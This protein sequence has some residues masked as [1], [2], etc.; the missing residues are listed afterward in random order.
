MK[1]RKPVLLALTLLALCAGGCGGRGAGDAVEHGGGAG[2]RSRVASERG[3]ADAV[4]GRG[5]NGT[6]ERGGRGGG[7]G[8]S[9]K[10]F[11]QK[12]GK[13]IDKERHADIDAISKKPKLVDTLRYNALMDSL[14]NGDTTGLWP[15]KSA[16]YPYKGAI[17]PYYR[18]VAYYGN[19]YS[20]RMGV[21]GEYP[22]DTLWQKL[23]AEV[24]KWEKADPSTPVK[25]AI[26]YIVTT[27]QGE[28]GKDSLSRMRMPKSQIDSALSIARLGD[29]LL[30]F[31][32]QAGLSNLRHEAPA[33]D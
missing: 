9:G 4:R 24:A 19:L 21:L 11:S 10:P 28:P 1:G 27:A 25:P 13:R 8:C 7:F 30:L 2:E 20:K 18:V 29:P 16:P 14:A 23:N 17:L 22:P 6:G 15:V 32:I 31:D 12:A 33:I 26:H 3:R 5:S